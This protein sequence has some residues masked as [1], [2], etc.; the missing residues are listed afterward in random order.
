MK[1]EIVQENFGELCLDSGTTRTLVGIKQF[2][3]YDEEYNQIITKKRSASSFKFGATT[4]Q[5]MGSFTGRIPLA[6]N[7][8]L[9][10]KTHMI[11][12]N[13][14]LLIGLDILTY[15]CNMT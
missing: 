4:Y 3:G 13:V 14:P 15:S 1:P 7:T 11:P 8:R 12:I 9:C 5:S 6:N 2:I 10:I